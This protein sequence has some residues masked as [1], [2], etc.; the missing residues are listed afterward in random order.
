MPDTTEAAFLDSLFE[1]A[2]DAMRAASARRSF[3]PRFVVEGTRAMARHLGMTEVCM[4]EAL[5]EAVLYQCFL[6]SV[7]AA[8]PSHFTEAHCRLPD[9]FAL[10]RKRLAE[11]EPHPQLAFLTFHMSGVPLVLMLLNACC[12]SLRN[13]PRHVLIAPLNMA[14][15]AEESGRWLLQAA[16]VIATDSAGLRRLVAGLRDGSIQRIATLVDGPQPPGAPGVRALN[17]L[18]AGLG[19]RT[20]VLRRMLSMG[21]PVLPVTH[22]WHLDRLT[23]EFGPVLR[24]PGEGIDAVAGIIEDMLRRHPEQWLNWPAARLRT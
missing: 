6:P 2:R 5:G 24:S 8:N 4:R 22:F 1:R 7:L 15:L 11:L 13:G 14:W 23:L 17:G 21:I 16:D 18:S 3:P 12:L 10:V 19:F 20:G 9:S